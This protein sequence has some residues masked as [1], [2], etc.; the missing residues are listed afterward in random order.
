MRTSPVTTCPHTGKLAPA[1]I[2]RIFEE[3]MDGE[4]SS[5][6]IKALG[7]FEHLNVR[8]AYFNCV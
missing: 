3:F 5:G 8:N 2:Q 4:V 1:E 7:Y 6:R